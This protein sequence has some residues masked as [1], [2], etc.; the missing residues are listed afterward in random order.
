[1]GA[2]DSTSLEADLKEYYADG[3]VKNVAYEVAGTFFAMARKK[4]DLS[5][6]ALHQPIQIGIA[7]GRSGNSSTAL[8][9]K[10]GNTYKKFVI[11]MAED[12]GATSIT[13]RVAKETR[14]NRGAFFD[15]VQREMDGIIQSLTRSASIQ[16]QRNGGGARGQV[17]AT[18]AI[19]TTVLTLSNPEDAK[20]FDIGMKVQASDTDGTS[21]SVH[22]GT[23]TIANIDEDAGTLTASAN[24]TTGIASI[25][26]SDYLF[27]EGDFGTMIKGLPAWIPPTAP[28]GG[29]NFFGVD[30]S[31]HVT[32]LA[33]SRITATTLPIAQAIRNL[34]SKLGG[35][36][37]TQAKHWFSSHEKYNNLVLE[38]GSKQ[39]F[40]VQGK[41]FDAEVFFAG[42]KVHGAGGVIEAYPDHTCMP[43]YGYLLNMK[44]I[45]LGSMGPVPDV[46]DDDGQT[47]LR[48]GLG[49][50][51]EYRVDYLANLVFDNTRDQGI[52]DL[53]S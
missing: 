33:G 29:D 15:A 13:R 1:M 37:G 6:E 3:G 34:S 5:G 11:T 20:N 51:V 26:A 32:M 45:Y 7:Q 25:G 43:Q 4:E 24:W 22:S 18:T 42:V 21:G 16:C 9:N 49:W 38:L 50:S 36:G 39:E 14:N 52:A 19:S 46:F 17:H 10:T 40:M 35:R 48:D 2:A 53:G 31:V 47:L 8:A 12:F 27:Q 28:T 30:R 44:D 41:A 23:A